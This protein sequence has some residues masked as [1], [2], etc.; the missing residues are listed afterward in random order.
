MSDTIVTVNDVINVIEV[1]EDG[2]VNLPLSYSSIDTTEI[3][4]QINENSDIT[5]IESHAVVA[6]TTVTVV[7]SEDAVP[8]TSRVDFIS[9]DVFY[10]GEAAPGSLESQ[11]VWKITKT[12]I[13][14]VDGDVQV[15]YADGVGTN[16]KIWNSRAIYNYS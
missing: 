3:V 12:T 10:K 9:D 5:F 4:H 1:L 8:I 6:Y 14:P 11:A 16:T 13:N 2:V 15:L 7:G